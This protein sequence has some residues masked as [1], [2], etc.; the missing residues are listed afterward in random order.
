M[1]KSLEKNIREILEQIEPGAS[2]LQKTPHRVAKSYTELFEG[3]AQSPEQIVGDALYKAPT[4]EMI[5]LRDIPFSSYCEHHMLPIIGHTHIGYMPD[6]F[7]IGASKIA[8]LVDCFAH[9]LQ[10]QE[11][12]TVAIVESLTLVSK[13]KGIAVSMA[14]EHYCIT[15]RGTKKKWT[16]L[17][18]RHFSGVFCTDPV[19]R[20]EF[21]K[22]SRL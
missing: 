5:V 14:A 9:R 2:R 22:T 3:Y 10:L 11:C 6:T 20:Q 13:P 4:Q 18:T 21:L 12:L 15:Q 19:L 17:M 7:I 16:Q 1:V 8:R